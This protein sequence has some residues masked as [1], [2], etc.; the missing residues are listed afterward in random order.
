MKEYK[1]LSESK[2][3]NDIDELIKPYDD[4]IDA[5]EKARKSYEKIKINDFKE[6]LTYEM[7][8][9]LEPAGRHDMALHGEYFMAD[10]IGDIFEACR[11][12]RNGEFDQKTVMKLRSAVDRLEKFNRDYEKTIDKYK[13]KHTTDIYVSYSRV[14]YD[15][16]KHFNDRLENLKGFAIDLHGDLDDAFHNVNVPQVNKS[17]ARKALFKSLSLFRRSL[18]SASR[19]ERN[20]INKIVMMKTKK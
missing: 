10:R 8:S 15:N 3:K 17:R 18:E 1:L 11:K 7:S 14:A 2:N 19:D 6:I 4:C 5:N 12:I 20:F 16:L 13:K 9:E